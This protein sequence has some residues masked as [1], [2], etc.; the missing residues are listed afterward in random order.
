MASNR[1]LS[2]GSTF[3][4]IGSHSIYEETYEKMLLQF[5][6]E[7]FPDHFCFEFKHELRVPRQTN[8][9]PDLILIDR[10]YQEW[11]LVEV[12]VARHSWS[13]HVADQ[14][15]RLELAEMPRVM[16]S[17]MCAVQLDIDERRVSML[18]QSQLQ[19]VLVVC[20]DSPR[21]SEKFAETSAELL[22]VRP[23]RNERHAL[24][25]QSERE[26]RRRRRNI[27]T[28]LSTPTA[29]QPGWYRIEA[30][31]AIPIHLSEVS[32]IFDNEV[33]PGKIR[34]IGQDWFLVVSHGLSIVSTTQLAITGVRD[35]YLD[36]NG[37]V[38]ENDH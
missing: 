14:V 8:V 3:Y 12:E 18:F 9:K 33:V 6:E 30:P 27:V 4:E 29:S 10:E 37:K 16:I 25:L 32:L 15:E 5:K 17:R 19:R 26:F 24:M 13:G 11:V 21:W 35:S 22:V 20:N 7:L 38:I 34:R 1:I 23:F 28:N 36:L 2:E 31:H